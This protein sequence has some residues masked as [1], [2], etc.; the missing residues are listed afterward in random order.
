MYYETISFQHLSSLIIL[1]YFILCLNQAMG[2][3]DVKVSKAAPRWWDVRV[4][5]LAMALVILALLVAIVVVVIKHNALPYCDSAS[6]I[7]PRNWENPGIFEDL[8]PGEMKMVRDYMLG[9]ESLN[10]QPHESATLNSS[11]IYLIDLQI[12]L[13]SAVRQ[14][15]DRGNR[16]PGRAAKV[17]LFRGDMSSP[18]IEE[19]L[20]G[21]L[22][23]PTYYHLVANPSYR[24]IPI[25]FTSR[26]VDSIEYKLLFSLLRELSEK[27]YPIF[28]ESYGLHYHNCTRGVDCILFYDIGPRGV[29]SGDRMSWFWAFRDVEGFYLHPLGFEMQI[30]HHSVDP[31]EWTV[32]RVVYNGQMF[33]TVD[34]LLEAYRAGGVMKLHLHMDQFDAEYSSYKRRGPGHYDVPRQ[35]P[36]LYEPEGRRFSVDGQ[37]VQYFGWN[38]NFRI[39]TS[40]GLQLFDVRFQGERIAYEISLQEATVFYTGYGP[41]AIT[42]NYYDT[43]WLLGGSLFEL[44]P[45]V[46]CPTTASFHD[47]YHFFDD[48]GPKHYRNVV[49]IFEQNSGIPIRRHYANDFA[50]GYGFYGGLAGY[51]LVVRTIT[52]VWNYDYIF[53]YI[54][55]LNG[56]IEIKVSATGYPQASFALEEERRYGGLIYDNVVANFHQH[57]FHY[58]V[59]LDIVGTVNRYATIDIS[60]ETV[61]NPWIPG[62]NKTQ[63][64]FDTKLK[65][66]EVHA[67]TEF[68]FDKPKY[69][70]V[71]ND[72]ASNRYGSHRAYRIDHRAMSKYLLDGVDVTEAAGWAKYQMAVT[73]YDDIEE[74]SS[75]IYAQNEP[76]DPVLDFRRFVED[77]DSIVD[78]DLVFWLTA[79]VHHIPHSE[80]VPSTATPA[81]QFSM[82]L[83]PFNYFHECPSMV[84]SDAVHIQPEDNYN[85]IT[86]DT[87]GTSTSSKCVPPTGASVNA[88]N[89]TRPVV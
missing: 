38:L 70:I 19:Y 47:A 62:V 28:R 6:G 37:H 27:L 74:T 77:D 15:L 31:S 76:W 29:K 3:A 82:F 65:T 84:V 4:V 50:G 79:G 64:R 71:Y 10:L 17:I 69:H 32:T 59:D 34:R 11:Y 8:T 57:L 58:K 24:R 86:V 7:I 80:D 67:A 60:R 16:K 42:G 48:S 55:H 25:P 61:P 1:F 83:R 40:T 68:N 41:V 66:T 89:G 14:Y 18:R 43:S 45:G 56:I 63:M 5:M 46:D 52:N 87:F 75:S 54:F 20:V 36:R 85:K 39:R 9:I 72:K 88:Y 78:E 81:N 30:D 51:S 49:C 2:E 44:V 22:P 21:P 26:M 33:A 12:P 23:N 53:D 35:G 13:K 73:K